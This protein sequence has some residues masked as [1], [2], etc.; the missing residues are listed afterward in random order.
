MQANKLGYCLPA[1]KLNGNEALT[2]SHHNDTT[3]PI[4]GHNIKWGSNNITITDLQ[5]KTICYI[6]IPYIINMFVIISKSKCSP[7][8]VNTAKKSNMSM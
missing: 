7:I 4:F 3:I 6:I 1:D 2:I 5:K 8:I